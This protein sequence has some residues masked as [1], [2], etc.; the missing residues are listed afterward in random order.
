MELSSDERQIFQ[1]HPSWRSALAFYVKGLLLIIVIGAIVAGVTAVSSSD[2]QW[3]WVGL[4]AIV[5]LIGVIII[6]YIR[7]IITTYTVT[8]Q[9]LYIRKGLLSKTEQETKLARVQNVNTK[10]SLMERML[11]VGDV[12]FDTAGSENY[13]FSFRG[14]ANPQEVVHAVHTA[15][16]E[17]GEDSEPESSETPSKS[18]GI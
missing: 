10:Q 14:V 2:I 4:V 3:D 8:N 9:R 13:D 15:Q 11:K 16:R 5:F 12:S 7:R 17:A 1:A 6:G 18:E